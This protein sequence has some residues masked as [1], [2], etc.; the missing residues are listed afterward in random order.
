MIEYCYILF[1]NRDRTVVLLVD[2]PLITRG[3][4]IDAAMAD[5]ASRLTATIPTTFKAVEELAAAGPVAP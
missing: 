5:T 3:T 4:V 1:A 2:C